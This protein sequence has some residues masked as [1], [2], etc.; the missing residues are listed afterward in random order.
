MSLDVY[1]IFERASKQP[2][3]SGIYVRE[4]GST[5]E[6]SKKEWDERFPG[7]LPVVYHFD[8]GDNCVHSGNITHNLSRMAKESG[9]Y[10]VLWRPEEVGVITASD[11]IEPLSRGLA[12]LKRYPDGY[13]ALN[14]E[15]GWGDYEGL[16]QFVENYLKACTR[17]PAA[18]VSVSR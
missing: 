11:L 14:P 17:F 16:V 4:N 6:I 15:N 7:V 9:L 12:R 18:M 10:E 13:R 1:L 8:D 3:G 5:R 2:S